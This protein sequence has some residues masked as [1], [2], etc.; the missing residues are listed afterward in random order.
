VYDFSTTTRMSYYPHNEPV[1][2]AAHRP[3][4]RSRSL[5]RADS[6]G[7]TS[8]TLVPTATIVD[9][10]LAGTPVPVPLNQALQRQPPV[11]PAEMQI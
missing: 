1:R 10:S 11:L 5:E 9:R 4:P 8:E 6:A 7:R 3:R 2:A